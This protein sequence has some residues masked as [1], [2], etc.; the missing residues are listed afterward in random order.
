MK[1]GRKKQCHTNNKAKQHNTPNMYDSCNKVRLHGNGYTFF[2]SLL[3][4]TPG[5]ELEDP[6][7]STK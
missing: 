5:S 2:S 6:R 4:M 1:E 3:K 7:H